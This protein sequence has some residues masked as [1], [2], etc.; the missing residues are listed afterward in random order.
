MLCCSHFHEDVVVTTKTPEKIKRRDAN[1]FIQIGSPFS[2]DY[3][4]EKVSERPI[5]YHFDVLTKKSGLSKEALYDFTSEL[6]DTKKHGDRRGGAAGITEMKSKCEL[7]QKKIL[8][9]FKSRKPCKI[10]ISLFVFLW[11]KPFTD[12]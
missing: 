11:P 4:K 6:T 1:W 8:F 9:N 5:D 10:H 7:D 3:W 12:V 2:E